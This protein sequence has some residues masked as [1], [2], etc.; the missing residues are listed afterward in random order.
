MT[1]NNNETTDFGN[2]FSTPVQR[3]FHK[4][5]RF[6]KPGEYPVRLLSSVLL[7]NTFLPLVITD[8]DTGISKTK[9]TPFN[10]KADENGFI[11]NN[12]L[13]KIG[14]VE[15]SLMTELYG[16][17]DKRSYAGKLLPKKVYRALGFDKS[18]TEGSDSNVFAFFDYKTEFRDCLEDD[19]Q[20]KVYPTNRDI[21]ING[22]MFLYDLIIK[23]VGTGQFGTKWS[24]YPMEKI[25]Q[26]SPFSG[27]LRKADL[28][29]NPEG[30][31]KWVNEIMASGE[32]EK[33][34]TPEQYVL[35]KSVNFRFKQLIHDS[36]NYYESDEQILEKLA[37][38]P[39]DLSAK[40]KEGK[41][42]F[43]PQL[44]PRIAQE[45]D[46]NLKQLDF[47]QNVYMLE[48][49]KTEDFNIN[50]QPQTPVNNVI[51]NKTVDES[52]NTS[53][54]VVEGDEEWL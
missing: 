7:Y 41:N 39:I 18:G 48:G 20:W 11:P 24:C 27:K 30:L 12:I 52:N 43:V 26:Q 25:G 32:F 17:D 3:T 51:Q 16:K 50:P 5:M 23:R 15:R 44:L 14:Q 31:A 42:I 2:E 19:V 45:F 1:N 36:L 38:C 35:M 13:K 9:L 53:A 46:K 47:G 10:I 22:P 29:K 28:Y 8:A 6:E 54:E 34:F 4:F 21:L 40:D 37:Q 33:L 49:P